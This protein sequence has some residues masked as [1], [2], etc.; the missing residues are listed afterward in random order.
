M[1]RRIFAGVLAVVLL[2]GMVLAV[3]PTAFADTDTVE[4]W[5]AEDFVAFAKNCTLDTWSENKTVYLMCDIDFSDTEF[6]PVPTFGG[7]FYGNGFTLSGIRVGA[8]ALTEGSFATSVRT[9]KSPVCVCVEASCRR[10]PK[11]L[12]AALS[13]KT[14]AW[15]NPV[16]LR[17]WS[18]A[19]MW[20]AVWSAT[21]RILE[22]SS[23]VRRRGRS[24]VKTPP[25]ES[26][27]KT[28]G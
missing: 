19:K 11:V 24:A 7:T 28:V 1:K 4:L 3:L 25:E 10:V 6:L 27:G 9:E 16:R 20:S 15:W 14:A 5:S 13:E 12:S 17:D 8:K 26:Q 23:P 18:K 22:K 21:I 2:V